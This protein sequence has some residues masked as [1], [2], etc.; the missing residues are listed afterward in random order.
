MSEQ[1]GSAVLGTGDVSGAHIDA[2]QADSRTEVR[3]ILSRD[4]AKAEAKALEHGLE[5]CRAYTDLD[6]LLQSEDIHLVSICT[7]HHLHVEQGVACAEAGKH[8]VVEKPIALDLGGLRKLDAAVISALD[9]VAWLLRGNHV[10]EAHR[11]VL[12]ETLRGLA[13]GAGDKDVFAA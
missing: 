9:S 10:P 8:V 1:L 4:H 5:N 13:T 6:E 7:P 3:A 2:Y 12:A 11:A